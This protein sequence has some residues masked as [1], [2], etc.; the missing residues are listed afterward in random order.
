MLM[1]C[2]MAMLAYTDADTNASIETLKTYEQPGGDEYLGLAHASIIADNGRM[3]VLDPS[4]PRVLIWNEDGS[5]HSAFG[6]QGEGPGEMLRPVQI[7]SKG[8]H[9]YIWQMN[10]KISRYSMD[11]EYQQDITI[12]G[13]WPRRFSVL[14]DEQLL[15]GYRGFE[16]GKFYA[17]FETR[18]ADG[19]L[20]KQVGR[21]QNK[22]FLAVK[23]GENNAE[24]K[25]YMGDVE[26]QTTP[27][28]GAWFGFGDE[29]ELTQVGANGEVIG[30]RT[31]ELP[32]SKPT[33]AERAH[34]EDMTF[35]TPDGKRVKLKNMPGIKIHFDRQKAH[36]THFLI[37]GD[38]VA[39][40]LTPVGSANSIGDG[41]SAGT[42]FVNDLKTGKLLSRGSYAFPEDSQVH[43][44][45]GR[46]T[47]F[48]AD[49]DE[50]YQIKEIT[51]KG[52]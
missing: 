37:K 16:A 19:A 44:R 34:V 27:D 22:G 2:L 7:T 13:P 33:D 36:Y 1:F 18:K 11:G 46:I 43:Y 52:L 14:N 45:D 9:L 25:A 4:Q 42:Y 17:V 35:P 5:F 49:G 6:Q 3:Y 41:Y 26:V 50:G 20:N 29:K 24:M 47:A 51:L 32:S 39:F 23:P 38:K 21:I 8:E 30:T 31:F 40:V 15:I 12:N 10:G 48:I 28:G